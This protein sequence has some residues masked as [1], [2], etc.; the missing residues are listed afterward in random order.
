MF[1]PKHRATVSACS[2]STTVAHLDIGTINTRNLVA[3]IAPF[4]RTT[5][6]ASMLFTTLAIL[7]KTILMAKCLFAASANFIG[8]SIHLPLQIHEISL[9]IRNFFLVRILVTAGQI[10]IIAA[11]EIIPIFQNSI[12]NLKKSCQNSTLSFPPMLGITNEQE[13]AKICKDI[14]REHARQDRDD[15]RFVQHHGFLPRFVHIV[16]L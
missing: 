3:F 13:G 8:G 7:H 12:K 5:I 16:F 2:F 14:G 1:T 4:G 9:V 15:S 11:T 10:T 6:H